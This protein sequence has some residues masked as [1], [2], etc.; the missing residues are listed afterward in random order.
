VPPVLPIVV[1]GST[2]R[3]GQTIVRALRD[4]PQWR[5]GAAVASAGSARIGQD[6]ASAGD[7]SGVLVSSDARLAVEGAAVAVDFSLPAAVSV[8][9]E[10]CVAAGVPLLVGTTGLDSATR[11]ILE[12]AAQRIG[13]LIAPNTSVGVGV[14][15]QLVA[16]AARSL[17]KGFDAEILEAHHRDKRDAPSGTALALG[18]A[19]AA[20]RGQSL[21]SA[22]VF[23]RHGNAAT[24]V[25]GS[26]GFAVV[27]A[28]DIVGEHTVM[29][30]T[31]GERIEISH[32]ATDRLTFARGALRAAEWLI[33]RP[34]GLY[35]MQDVLGRSS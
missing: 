31:E 14:L 21:E 29:F 7:P 32:R 28:G 27:R 1:F 11:G 9:A 30:A 8:H 2:G 23:D 33:G 20:A 34:P 12:L 3:M 5:L 16:I 24:R 4:A 35:C 25:P 6:A 26:I 22:A 18:Q 10:A 13:V 17:G 19:V 15:C